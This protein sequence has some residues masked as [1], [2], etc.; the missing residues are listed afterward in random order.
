MG[1][2]QCVGTQAP[3][4]IMNTVPEGEFVKVLATSFLFGV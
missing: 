2:P 3:G 4:G 1:E